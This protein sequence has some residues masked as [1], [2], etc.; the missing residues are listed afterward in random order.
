M[1]SSSSTT[2]V[3][4]LRDLPYQ[5]AEYVAEFT[6]MLRD[7]RAACGPRPFERCPHRAAVAGAYLLLEGDWENLVTVSEHL[8]AAPETARRS[9]SAP[10]SP[11][12]WSSG[13]AASTGAT[14]TWTPTRA[15]PRST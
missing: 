15:A 2:C 10:G 9:W 3:L 1:P 11:P 6:A 13:T 14:R 12:T 5:E 8:L 7:Y 4:Y